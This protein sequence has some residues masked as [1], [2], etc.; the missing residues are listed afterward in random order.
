MAYRKYGA[1][2]R[3]LLLTPLLDIIFLVLL[4]FVVN[5]NFSDRNHIPVDNPKSVSESEATNQEVIITLGLDEKIFL[6][7]EAC[8][9]SELKEK[10]IV[11]KNSKGID[12]VQVDGDK[13]ISYQ[14][15][16]SVIDQIKLS[17]I[18]QIALLTKENE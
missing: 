14:F 1:K 2:N 17:G 9:I 8:T 18:E 3:A 16:V 4:F 13:N 6:D 10:L 12:I 5:S 15:L 11:I 7:G